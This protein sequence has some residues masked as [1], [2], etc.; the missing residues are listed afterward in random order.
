MIQSRTQERVS[1]VLSM[2]TTHRGCIEPGRTWTKR[3]QT[4]S[5]EDIGAVPS[6]CK[7][8]LDR[9]DP[10]DNRLV[11]AEAEIKGVPQF[12]GAFTGDGGVTGTVGH[13]GSDHP[14]GVSFPG[15]SNSALSEARRGEQHKAIV[16]I[17]SPNSADP[18]GM[19]L[20]N[21]PSYRSPFGPP[22]LHLPPA[23]EPHLR[24]NSERHREVTCHVAA[25]RRR[26]IAANV[27]ALG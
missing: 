2:S 23:S 21:A 22:M 24:T 25:I 6:V 12:D 9:V 5:L 7:I 18:M 4:G 13:L 1:R 3:R 19:V 20:S 26:A 10:A 14:I 15:D 17:S 11:T 16:S 27:E 8:E